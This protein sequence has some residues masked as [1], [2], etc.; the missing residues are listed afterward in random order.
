MQ[1]ANL[2]EANLHQACLQEVNL[3]EAVLGHTVFE[4][5]CLSGAIGLDTCR[6]QTPSRFDFGSL[7]Q[8]GC[9]P[10]NLLA[11]CGW[12]NELTAQALAH[13]EERPP[14][15]I[16]ERAAAVPL[17]W[18]A[19]VVGLFSEVGVLLQQRHPDVACKSHIEQDATMVRLIVETPAMH[20]ETIE[21]T[22]QTFVLCGGR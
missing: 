20:R 17:A 19:A 13:G 6:H 11:Q 2:Q 1:W 16:I 4:Q 12:S 9:L 21:Q 15:G 18:H 5:T 3:H 14:Q 10:E 7:A 22:V 8:S